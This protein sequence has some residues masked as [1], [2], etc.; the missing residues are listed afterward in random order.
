MVDINAIFSL[1]PTGILA[2]SVIK[3]AFFSLGTDSPVNAD[4]SICKFALS[5]SLISAGIKRPASIIIIS[6]GTKSSEFISTT[7]PL[8]LTALL[9]VV[10]CCNASSAFSAFD[11]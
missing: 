1:S 11:S 10:I 3:L 7:S 9:G 4:S 6:P 5:I 8:R 2:S